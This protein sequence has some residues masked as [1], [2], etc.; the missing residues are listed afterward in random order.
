MFVFSRKA[1]K[2]LALALCVPT[3]TFAQATQTP[4]SAPIKI[5]MIEGLSGPF[6][7]TGEAVFRNLIW[8]VERVNARGGVKIA[9]SGELA[10]GGRPLA[11]ERYDSKGQ[12]EEALTALKSAIDD[13]AQFIMQ[14]NSSAT[15]AALID[16]INKHNEREPGKRVLFLNYSAVDPILTNEKCSFWHFRFD[17]HADMRITAL[18]EVLKEDKALKSVYIIGQDYSFGHA[19]AREAKRQLAA[20][21]PDVQ[22]VGD[23]LHP[24]GRVKDFLPYA[25]K[26]KASGAQ[27][28]ITGNW[29]NDLTLLVKA[30]KEV[31]FEG[32]FYTFYGNA[33][34]APAAIGDAGIG[35][36]VAVADW[37]PNVQ[38]AQS[39]AFYQSFRQRFPHPAD[40]YV[41]M[42]MQLM[43]E[44]LAQAIEKANTTNSI[45]VARQLERARVVFGSQSGAMRAADHQF[46]QP[47]VVGVMDKQGA[48]GVKFDVEGSGYGFRVIKTIAAK[49][50]ELPTTC[51][52]Q[53]PV[54]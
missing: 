52:M 48:P 5:A 12:N 53:R 8:A 19:V 41:H 3:L 46:Q 30:A 29:G 2:L 35:K 47:L 50:A 42:R 21:R 23:E 1:L 44:S 36:V 26:I 24:V 40:D 32:K 6:A 49:R 25:A 20:S 14:G 34:G 28:V 13:G 4:I 11:L 38:T 16:A 33:L 9:A 39:E 15:A 27:A 31:G 37:L 45:A 22:V 7:N 43:V 51:K 18:M 54:E 10:G 17:A